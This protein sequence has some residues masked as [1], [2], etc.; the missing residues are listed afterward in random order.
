MNFRRNN[1]GQDESGRPDFIED[2]MNQGTLYPYLTLSLRDTVKDQCFE[3]ECGLDQA[4]DDE[5][6]AD[7][8]G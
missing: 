7:D 6:Q 5:H 1:K 2:H 4:H 8:G 3:S